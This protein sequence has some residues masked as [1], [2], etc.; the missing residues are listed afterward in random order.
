VNPT[1]PAG[2]T[3]SAALPRQTPTAAQLGSDKTT[4]QF[5]FAITAE[6][7]NRGQERFNINCAPCHS[8][9]GD[10][11]GM[12]VQRGFRKPVSFHDERVRTA[13]NGHFYDVITNGLGA[14]P[15][16]S[17][18]LSVE[19]RWKV[20]AY[21]RALQLSQRASESDVPPA[22]RAKLAAGQPTAPSQPGTGGQHQ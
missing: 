15:S 11:N 6:V 9:I 3:P 14:M 21:I 19:D 12:I 1:P 10:G 4:N 5:P 16:Y 20:V 2:A 17:D 22:E 13:P 7:L 8:R 18:K